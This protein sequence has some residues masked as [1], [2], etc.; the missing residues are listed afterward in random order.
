ME[1]S[2]N[3]VQATDRNALV[4]YGSETGNAQDIAEDLGRAVE[5]MRF[6]AT[7]EEM[8]AVELASALLSST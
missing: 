8:N 2:S 7:V 1:S 3:D 6:K 5:R 4:L